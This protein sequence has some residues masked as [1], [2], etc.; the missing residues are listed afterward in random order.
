MKAFFL[1]LILAVSTNAVADIKIIVPFAAG[2][3]FDIVARQY[4]K[5]LEKEAVE[6]SIENV[7]GAGSLIGTRRLQ[8]SPP[9][10]LMITSSSF[11]ANIVKGEFRL[12]EF[13]P[14]SVIASSPLFLVTNKSKNLTCEKLRDPKTKYFIGN[15]GKDSITSIPSAFVVEAYSHITEIPYKGIAQASTDLLGNHITGMF[16]SSLSSNRPEFDVLANTTAGKFE[17][18]ASLKECLGIDKVVQT[19]WL[20]LAS[21]NSD[22]KFIDRMN[23]LAIKFVNTQEMQTFFKEQGM[24]SRA[25]SLDATRSSVKIENENWKKLL[26]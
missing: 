7:V 5:F 14:V 22:T 10:T 16:I 26:K 17:G 23:S 12:D 9:N 24:V 2:G 20:M 1:A 3:S 15:A 11:Y 21:P 8:S 13:T 6:S 19:Q 18:I 25:A 4:S